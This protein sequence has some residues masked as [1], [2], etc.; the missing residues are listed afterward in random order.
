M[1]I[2]NIHQAKTHL[3]SLIESALQGEDVII[4]KAGKPLVRLVPCHLNPEPRK[5]GLWEGKVKIAKDF[6]NTPEDIINSFL[7]E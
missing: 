7:G 3:S 5:P 2:T 4:S 1:K 6:D